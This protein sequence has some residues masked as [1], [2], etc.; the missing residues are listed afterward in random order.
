MRYYFVSDIWYTYWEVLFVVE[1]ICN[2]N[3][4]FFVCWRAGVAQLAFYRI[5]IPEGT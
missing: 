2:P 1:T 4:K 3:D 5:Q